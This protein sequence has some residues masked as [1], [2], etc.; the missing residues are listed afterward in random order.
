MCVGRG[1]EG[2]RDLHI[3]TAVA[4]QETVITCGSGTVYL[5]ISSSA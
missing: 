1:V 3:C 2:E 4:T 5:E